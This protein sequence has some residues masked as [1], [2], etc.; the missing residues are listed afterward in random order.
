LCAPDFD[1]LNVPS[2]HFMGVGKDANK[3]KIWAAG[4]LVAVYVD[5]LNTDWSSGGVQRAADV[6]AS[7]K[8]NFPCGVPEWFILNE[9][10]ASL[11]PTNASYRQ[12]VID[13]AKAMKNTHGKSVV[14]A[15]PFPKPGAN[16]T[17][18]TELQKYGFIGA[19]VYLS[20]KEV[21]AYGNSVSWCEDQYQAAIDAY[22]ALGVPK[23]RLYLFEHFGNTDSTVGWGRAGVSVDGWHNAIKARSEAIKNLGFAGFLSYGWAFN[24]MHAPESDRLA[25]M[26]TYVQQDL[27]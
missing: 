3:A 11:W 13:F 25:F 4:N 9:I 26:A 16:A 8:E 7:A 21:N 27:P 12:F 14:I 22:G 2:A 18:W 1:A 15:A 23:S 20:G 10:S 5:D 24:A 17:S 6:M 19:E